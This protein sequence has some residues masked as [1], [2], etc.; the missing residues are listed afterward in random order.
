VVLYNASANIDDIGFHLI[1]DTIPLAKP[2]PAPKPRKEI[3]VD[4]KVLERYVGEYSFTPAIAVTV[5][6][7]GN[8]LFVQATGQ[9]KVPVYPESETDFFL[10]IVDAQISFVKDASGAVTGMVL[11]Q[12]GQDQSATKVK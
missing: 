11:H 12:N 2:R 7:E 9:S 1:D 8:Q 10:K 5:T 4:P 3:A 6:L